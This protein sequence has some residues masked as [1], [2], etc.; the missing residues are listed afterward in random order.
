MGCTSLWS[1][2][3]GSLLGACLALSLIIGLEV[4][5]GG[6][7]GTT[8]LSWLASLSE[9]VTAG[10]ADN[11][12]FISLVKGK[13]GKISEGVVW[14]YLLRVER[15]RPQVKINPQEPEGS[16]FST[17]IE[18]PH[19]FPSQVTGSGSWPINVLTPTSSKTGTWIFTVTQSSLQWGLWFGFLQ[20]VL[21]GCQRDDSLPGHT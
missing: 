15:L 19:I 5:I 7:W 1:T 6:P 9:K 17:S 21:C 20:L 2:H 11:E 12:G 13:K 16:K 3:S 18:S 14:V 10:L 4:S 8:V